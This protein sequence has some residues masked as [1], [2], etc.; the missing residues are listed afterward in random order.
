MKFWTPAQMGE[1]RKLWL[2]KQYSAAGIADILNEKFGTSFTRN[3]IIGKAH[4]MELSFM[5]N[6]PL[7]IKRKMRRES[8]KSIE[9]RT[10]I[11]TPGVTFDNMKS[12]M[13]HYIAGSPM[14][15]NTLFCGDPVH[16]G[17]SY[18][19][20]HVDA[21]YQKSPRTFIEAVFVK[22]ASAAKDKG[23]NFL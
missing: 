16:K 3:S 22:K 7:E 23:Y 21:C 18:C 19:R 1:M 2:S 20:K 6:L 5:G 11:K 14:G 13:C 17:Y 10:A 4:R 8:A 15:A 12:H 9:K